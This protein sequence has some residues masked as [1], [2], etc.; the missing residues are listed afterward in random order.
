MLADGTLPDGW[1]VKRRKLVKVG[2]PDKVDPVAGD[3][4]GAK[5]PIEQP[6][7][8]KHGRKHRKNRDKSKHGKNQHGKSKHGKSKHGESKHDKNQDG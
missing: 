2:K 7:G 8:K 4:H 6:T 1:T 5:Q 3:H